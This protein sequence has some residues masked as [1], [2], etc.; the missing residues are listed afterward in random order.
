MRLAD[1]PPA[2][3]AACLACP[4]VSPP[5]R[6][7]PILRGDRRVLGISP[8]PSLYRSGSWSHGVE[9]DRVGLQTPDHPSVDDRLTQR[10]AQRAETSATFLANGFVGDEREAVGAILDVLAQARARFGER[11][12]LRFDQASFAQAVNG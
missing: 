6:V 7:F 9:A 3:G 1:L 4:A 12:L 5:P 2:A 10:A 11:Q 8:D